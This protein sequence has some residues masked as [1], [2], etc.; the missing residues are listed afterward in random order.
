MEGSHPG[1]ELLLLVQPQRDTCHVQLG[2][3]DGPRGCNITAGPWGWDFSSWQAPRASS[4]DHPPPSNLSEGDGCPGAGGSYRHQCELSPPRLTPEPLPGLE[5]ILVYLLIAQ[6]IPLAAE[7]APLSPCSFPIQREGC[8]E[9]LWSLAWPQRLGEAS[10]ALCEARAE[11]LQTCGAVGAVGQPLPPPGDSTEGLAAQK[12]TLL[13]AAS[14]PPVSC[15][16]RAPSV[17]TPQGQ[18]N[19][20]QQQGNAPHVQKV[21][22][23]NAKLPPSPSCMGGEVE[24]RKR[25]QQTGPS[26]VAPSPV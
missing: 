13:N 24:G 8:D 3:P 11:G 17:P 10:G 23:S 6:N 16:S 25:R 21:G 26:C 5:G 14:R 12:D 7:R 18:P 9:R 2:C 22:I 19:S 4:T 15:M 1:C 20:P